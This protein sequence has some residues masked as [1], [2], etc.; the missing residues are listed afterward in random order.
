M[1]IS[2][3]TKLSTIQLVSASVIMILT[4]GSCKKQPPVTIVPGSRIHNIHM[5]ETIDS[6]MFK[7]GKPQMGDA[8]MGH[9]WG[10]WL[11]TVKVTRSDTVVH[12]MDVYFVVTGEYLGGI[13]T[14]H[15]IRTNNPNE[16]TAQGLHVGSTL[17][18]IRRV[19]P[20]IG[21]S[22]WRPYKKTDDITDS[23]ITYDAV[24]QGIAFDMVNS[25][26]T[27]AAGRIYK[28]C[29]SIIVH[30]PDQY[31]FEVYLPLFPDEKSLLRG[32]ESRDTLD[33]SDE[34]NR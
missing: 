22:S 19:Y 13:K 8:A 23:V 15:Q 26:K 29:S 28:V 6:V 27:D 16:Y 5:G 18:Q 25:T 34:L 32:R 21:W 31:A 4:V 10:F 20:K 11:D 7:L 2:N 33:S 14:V 30:I 1:R 12:R 24:S 17:D 9:A 3:M